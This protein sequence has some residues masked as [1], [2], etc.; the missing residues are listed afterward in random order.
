MAGVRVK[1]RAGGSSAWGG[2][3][4]L[5]FTGLEPSSPA[6]KIPARKGGIYTNGERRSS[7]SR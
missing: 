2:D 7:I 5:A 4:S 1:S 3:A 6:W